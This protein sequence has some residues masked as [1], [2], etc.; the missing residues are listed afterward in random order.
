MIYPKFP[1]G[2]IMTLGASVRHPSDGGLCQWR[3]VATERFGDVTEDCWTPNSGLDLFHVGSLSPDEGPRN[4]GSY[5]GPGLSVTTMPDFI[6]LILERADYPR[7]RLRPP[8]G[9]VRLANM[10]ALARNDRATELTDI[11]LADGL[12]RLQDIYVIEMACS[13]A[14]AIPWKDMALADPESVIS[15]A[16][17]VSIGEY[18]WTILENAEDALSICDQLDK[19]GLENAIKE[20]EGV[21]AGEELLAVWNAR[22][23]EP[24]PLVL[25]EELAWLRVLEQCGPFD[26]AWWD[27][28]YAIK[29]KSCPRG[30]IF[31]SKME[32]WEYEVYATS[33][34][35][36]EYTPDRCWW[37]L[38]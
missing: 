36:P 28:R 17:R 20:K 22:Y 23:T 32:S 7:I 38:T 6:A 19:L 33:D 30:V 14:E 31:E 10:H 3:R 11:A 35:D 15:L 1:L 13:N 25:V 2:Q 26:G 18:S 34:D 29:L 24:P 16:E 37:P 27:D 9:P 4:V 21:V 12:L 8:R 5:E